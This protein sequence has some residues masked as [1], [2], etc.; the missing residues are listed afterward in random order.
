MSIDNLK[1]EIKAYTTK[2]LAAIYD[3]SDKTFY[4]WILPFKEEIGI[5]RGRFYNI[6]QVRIIID[7][8][9]IPGTSITF[10]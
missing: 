2:E 4:K 1:L 9:G 8:L 3:I 5:K 7:K 6:N 10:K